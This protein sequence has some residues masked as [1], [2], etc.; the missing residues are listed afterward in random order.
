MRA[1]FLV[2]IL[3]ADLAWGDVRSQPGGRGRTAA[4][5]E[6]PPRGED[7]P[8]LILEAKPRVAYQATSEERRFVSAKSDQVW[9]Q[10]MEAGGE[11]SLLLRSP[12]LEGNGNR[13]LELRGGLDLFGR[14][15]S[16]T[17]RKV[18]VYSSEHDPKVLILVGR[19]HPARDSNLAAVQPFLS[20]VLPWRPWLVV[21]GRAWTTRFYPEYQDT[22][23]YQVFGVLGGAT[24]SWRAMA[25]RAFAEY[26]VAPTVDYQSFLRVLGLGTTLTVSLPPVTF[27]VGVRQVEVRADDGI[28]R[29]GMQESLVME[30]SVRALSDLGLGAGL[31]AT[32]LQSSSWVLGGL[33]MTDS[34]TNESVSL[35][36]GLPIDEFG[37]SLEG[38]YA[39]RSWIEVRGQYTHVA[40]AYYLNDGVSGAGY[41]V[42]ALQE[43]LDR[44]APLE[45]NKTALDVILR[46]VF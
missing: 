14:R 34:G 33:A 30:G 22:S 44:V 19:V 3:A 24:A 7:P 40:R 43:S 27:G 46:Y 32:W 41:T 25:W 21:D 17:T 16:G 45:I 4:P 18:Q 42:P 36:L 8:P 5:A 35:D 38:S 23:A 12:L 9:A 6:P 1:T 20:T 29:V 15:V 2:L 28:A 11:V 13:S 37:F 31:K 26:S 10:A 39:P